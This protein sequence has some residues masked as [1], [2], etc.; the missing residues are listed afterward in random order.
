MWKEYLRADCLLS[1]LSLNQSS[2]LAASE[3]TSHSR[4]TLAGSDVSRRKWLIPGAEHS[5]F[6]GQ[7]LDTKVD[8]Q[9]EE[10][11]LPR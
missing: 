7:P 9:P 11:C 4:S 6:T 5:I 2:E 1:V 8:S 3:H 10:T